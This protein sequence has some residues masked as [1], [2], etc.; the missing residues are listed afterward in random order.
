MY[1]L[2][3]GK[4]SVVARST[5]G[6]EKTVRFFYNGLAAAKQPSDQD[7]WSTVTSL[8]GDEEKA[9]VLPDDDD[10]QVNF[11]TVALSFPR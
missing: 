2:E 8:A 11:P 3:S 1:I 5:N 6:E 9:A 10:P 4:V 7:F